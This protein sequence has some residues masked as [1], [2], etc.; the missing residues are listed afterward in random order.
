M[1]GPR[2]VNP[3]LPCA[4]NQ[5][6]PT[7]VV[8][9]STVVQQLLKPLKIEQQMKPA[10]QQV[11]FEPLGQQTGLKASQQA[12]FELGGQ[13]I[14]GGALSQ[15]SMTPLTLQH[16]PLQQCLSLLQGWP[17]PLHLAKAV[18]I[19]A[20]PRILP[21]VV[22]AMVLRAW[23]REVGVARALVNSSKREG[24]ISFRPFYRQ[25]CLHKWAK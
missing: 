19:P 22:A 5:T 16:A 8:Q 7:P 4:G 14:A 18:P 9:P 25:R 21:M 15:Q 3:L 12:A 1:F 13:Q 17:P 20:R 2:E 6:Q 24:S 23:R 11:A 10:G